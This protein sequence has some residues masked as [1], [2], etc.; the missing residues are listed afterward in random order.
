MIKEEKA[1]VAAAK[2]E[3]ELNVNDMM[4]EMYNFVSKC[5]DEEVSKGIAPLPGVLDTLTILA[6]KYTNNENNTGRDCNNV[7]C[8][9]V[10]GNV[11]GIAR[12]KM[13]ALGIHDTGV[14][15]PLLQPQGGRVWD[16]VEDIRFLGGFGSDYCSG[17]IDKPDRNYLDRGEQIAICVQRCLDLSSS[18]LDKVIH[19]G[20]APSD[21]QAAKSYVN[22]PNK[23]PGLTVSCVGVATGTYSA[24]ELTKLCG[25][26]VE[27]I[28]E[29]IVL[30]QGQG[31]G[32]E[33]VFLKACG[34]I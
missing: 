33:E 21:I 9:L 8:G 23:P 34:L 3:V 13:F 2:E 22:H 6:S 25:E 14:F 28:W 26:R 7:A 31:V 11:E 20:D 29:P 19:V 10:T 5:N 16:G 12:R 27:G 32:N 18:P 4:D 15:T 30:E 24:D 1:L 17:S